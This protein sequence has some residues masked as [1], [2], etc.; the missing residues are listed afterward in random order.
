MKGSY[1]TD[2]YVDEQSSC[3]QLSQPQPDT[4]ATLDWTA[5]GFPTGMANAVTTEA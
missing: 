3:V 1:W 5:Y 2:H 4:P